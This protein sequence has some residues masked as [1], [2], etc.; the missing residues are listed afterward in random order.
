MIRPTF[1]FTYT[2]MFIFKYISYHDITL[3]LPLYFFERLPF[4]YNEVFQRFYSLSD[5]M[6]KL[7]YWPKILSKYYT[8]FYLTVNPSQEGDPYPSPLPSNQIFVCTMVHV[9]VSV[10]SELCYVLKS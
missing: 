10:Y 9:F 4:S 7:W 2:V 8:T 5:I 6:E 1:R 3:I